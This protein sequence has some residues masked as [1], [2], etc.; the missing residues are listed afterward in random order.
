MRGDLANYQQLGC[1][2]V[3]VTLAP[4]DRCFF[5]VVMNRKSRFRPRK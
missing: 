4:V 5:E 3:G 2:L 1:G